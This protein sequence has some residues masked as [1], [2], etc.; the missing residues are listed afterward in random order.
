MRKPKLKFS[1]STPNFSLPPIVVKKKAF[2]IPEHEQENNIIAQKLINSKSSI[3]VKSQLR[4]YNEKERI[5]KSLSKYHSLEGQFGSQ[6]I[7]RKKYIAELMLLK[8]MKIAEQTE[9]RLR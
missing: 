4:D 8:K 6:V 1:D 9:S 2:E 3:N 5:K 7:D